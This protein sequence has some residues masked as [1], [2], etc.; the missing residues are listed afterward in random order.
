[1]NVKVKEK[2]E[3]YIDVSEG[4]HTL[5]LSSLFFSLNGPIDAIGKDFYLKGGNLVEIVTNETFGWCFN[6]KEKKEAFD[7]IGRGE[8]PFDEKDYDL[9]LF[10]LIYH[11]ETVYVSSSLYENPLILDS[12]GSKAN[13]CLKLGIGIHQLEENEDFV[14]RLVVKKEIIIEEPN[15][16]FHQIQFVPIDSSASLPYQSDSSHDGQNGLISL[17]RNVSIQNFLFFSSDIRWI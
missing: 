16:I 5:T 12:C 3:L 9:F 11:N 8:N 6:E 7:I 4:Y 1:V 14:R 13:P 10:L 17:S 2:E 15:L